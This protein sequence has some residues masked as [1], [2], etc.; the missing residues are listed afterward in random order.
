[1]ALTQQ[2]PN[3]HN[4]DFSKIKDAQLGDF[5]YFAEEKERELKYKITK[6]PAKKSNR[7]AWLMVLVLLISLLGLGTFTLDEMRNK[8]QLLAEYKGQNQIAGVFDQNLLF[9]PIT[10]D[11]FSILPKEKPPTEFI[12]TKTSTKSEIFTDREASNTSYVAQ[13][14]ATENKKLKSGIEVSVIE[15]DNR[16]NS[17]QFG[18]FVLE[19]LGKNYE[20]KDKNFQIPKEIK[21]TKIEALNNPELEAIYYTGV[22]SDNYYIIKIYNQT[23]SDKK[24]EKITKFTDSILSSLYLN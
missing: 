11:W 19:K 16:Y 2:K 10:G 6:Q 3:I 20:I 23:E 13:V 24:Y 15:Y 4:F 22:T 8:N 1:M 21:L 12:K 7:F 14:D 17:E 5:D 18:Q 9:S